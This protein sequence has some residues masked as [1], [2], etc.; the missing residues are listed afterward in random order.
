MILQNV[1]AFESKEP[2][3]VMTTKDNC[4]KPHHSENLSIWF[5]QSVQHYRKCIMNTELGH[6]HFQKY[7][8]AIFTKKQQ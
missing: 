2:P 5:S 4:N 7:N 8:P 6:Q 1:G 3:M